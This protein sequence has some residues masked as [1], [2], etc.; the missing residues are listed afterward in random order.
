MTTPKD[1][2]ETR[3]HDYWHEQ[4]DRLSAPPGL[5][6]SAFDRARE[7]RVGQK[8]SGLTRRMVR[9]GLTAA[10]VLVAAG[11][12][13]FLT[14]A[15]IVILGEHAARPQGAPVASP[16]RPVALQLGQRM[17]LAV[18]PGR[19]WMLSYRQGAW[20]VWGRISASAHWTLLDRVSG[21]KSPGA[22]LAVGD[23]RAVLVTANPQGGF[24]AWRANAQGRHWQAWRLPPDREAQRAL[25]SAD[26][27]GL[28]L[29][30]QTGS[31][32]RLYRLSQRGRWVLTASTLPIGVTALSMATHDSGV[33]LAESGSLYQTNDGGHIWTP[34]G[35]PALNQFSVNLAPAAPSRRR[36][37]A[38][39][40]DENRG[41]LW[42]VQRGTLWQRVGGEWRRVAPLPFSGSVRSLVF[43][44]SRT[45][46]ILSSQGVVEMTHDGGRHWERLGL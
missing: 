41:R 44:S 16:A 14:H 7:E 32:N 25:V 5:A 30:L 21:P 45:G 12:G 29:A 11:L 2:V 23:G 36:S 8:S 4:L 13:L 31:V 15:P 37:G 1:D 34:V 42:M 40:V 6:Q 20:Q 9:S 39:M 33:L 18:S 46:Y 38:G 26:Q 27:G 43:I 24:R 3:L 17:A 22:S 28:Y 19:L 10:G 35:G